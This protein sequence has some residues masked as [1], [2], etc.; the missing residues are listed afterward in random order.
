[1]VI[2]TLLKAAYVDARYNPQKIKEYA[3]KVL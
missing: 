2:V 3:E 1:M